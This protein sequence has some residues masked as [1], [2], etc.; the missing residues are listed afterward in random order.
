MPQPVAT[1]QKDP[2]CMEKCL[3]K[4]GKTCEKI[5]GFFGK[6]KKEGGRTKRRRKRTRKR[7]KYKK[8]RTRKRRRKN[9]RSRK[10]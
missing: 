5:C 1:V 6:Y 7:R 2:D 3:K 8:K 10:K 4:G 9:K